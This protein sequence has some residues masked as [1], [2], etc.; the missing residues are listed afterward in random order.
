LADVELGDVLTINE[1]S[2]VPRPV[3]REQFEAEAAAA[4]PIEPG[5]QTISVDI[6]VTW[7]LE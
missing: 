4:V 6:Q 5:T 7:M 2:R 1:S 3:V